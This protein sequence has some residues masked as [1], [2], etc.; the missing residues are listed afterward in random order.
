MSRRAVN[1]FQRPEP[2]A[3]D[4]FSNIEDDDLI[5]VDDSVIAI[6]VNHDTFDTAFPLVAGLQYTGRYI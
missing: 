5:E 2:V 1:E 6:E 4:K 3:C